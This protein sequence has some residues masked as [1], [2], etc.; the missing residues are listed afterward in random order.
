MRGF[1]S[2]W[3]WVTTTSFAGELWVQQ[4][5]Q[6]VVPSSAPPQPRR[7]QRQSQEEEEVE[8]E[9]EEEEELRLDARRALRGAID[10]AAARPRGLGRSS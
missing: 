8:E 7:A 2:T 4:A 3:V 6:Q 9:E 1:V 10:G 5:L